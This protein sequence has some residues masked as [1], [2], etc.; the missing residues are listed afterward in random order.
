MLSLTK[1]HNPKLPF[2]IKK[3]NIICVN[4]R[5]PPLKSL[6]IANNVYVPTQVK[7]NKK[8]LLDAI[9]FLREFYYDKNFLGGSD[10][11]YISRAKSSK[12]FLVNEKE[13][14]KLL[15]SKYG[16]KTIFMEEIDFKDKIN[17]LSRAKVCLSIDGTSVLNYAFM[18]SGGKA[19]AL[20]AMDMAEYPIDSIFGIEFLPIVCDIVNPKNTNHMDGDVGTWFASDLY[21]D[22]PYIEEKLKSYEIEPYI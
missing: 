14:R 6:L 12:R 15:E 3:D 2:G 11:I 9:E 21:A 19:V 22:I 18:R 16:F 5:K 17:Y 13:F 8:Y 1:E 10:R 4:D 20:R 7:F